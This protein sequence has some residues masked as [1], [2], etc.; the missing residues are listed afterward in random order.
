MEREDN[1]ADGLEFDLNGPSTV[2]MCL[3]I[4]IIKVIASAELAFGYIVIRECLRAGAELCRRIRG[5]GNG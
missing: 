3:L 5:K 2:T 1:R 4:T